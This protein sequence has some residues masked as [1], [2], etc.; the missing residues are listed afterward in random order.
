MAAVRQES[1]ADVKSFSA[2]AID[3]GDFSGHAPRR[4]HSPQRTRAGAAEN[5]Y[6]V[7]VPVA[8]RDSTRLAKRLRRPAGHLDLLE[9]ASRP[10]RD[11]AT[12]RRP[13][14]SNCAFRAGQTPGLE[15]IQVANPYARL[16]PGCS[17]RELTSIGRK[18]HVR[19]VIL[20]FGQRDLEAR[21]IRSRRRPGPQRPGRYGR[22][23]GK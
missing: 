6:A 4:R 10:E 2:L 9:L 14:G 8:P 16:A 17:E 11:E 1:R 7:T 12:V 15:R 22:D 21:R 3:G 5:N 13:D 20:V 19:A 18:R 23:H